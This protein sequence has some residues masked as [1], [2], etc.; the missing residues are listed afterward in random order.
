VIAHV[1]AER[2][3][4]RRT[5]TA[6]PPDNSKKFSRA[7]RS[8]KKNT[9]YACKPSKIFWRMV[10]PADNSKKRGSAIAGSAKR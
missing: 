5:I 1:A 7:K 3:D 10:V 9:P 4:D 6:R 8:W 2:R